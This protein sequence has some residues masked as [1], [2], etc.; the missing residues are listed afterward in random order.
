MSNVI[1]IQPVA[2]EKIKQKPKKITKNIVVG[3]DVLE[4]LSGA[5][6]V[7]PLVI[8]R[9][10]IQNS[11][12]A[13]D[14][15]IN[16]RSLKEKEGFIE[17]VLDRENRSIKLIDNGAGLENKEF[18]KRLAAFGASKKRGTS[19]RGFRGVGRLSGFG[20]CRELIFRSRSSGDKLVYQLSWD[21]QKFKQ[22]LNDKN[23]SGDLNDV[24][25][26]VTEI[27]MFPSDSY[28]EHFFEVE[29]KG[30]IRCKN[31]LLLNEA[32]VRSYLEQVTPLPFNPDFKYA[33]EIQDKLDSYGVGKNYTIYLQDIHQSSDNGKEIPMPIYRPFSDSFYISDSL[34]DEFKG[35]QFFDLEGLDG[36]IVAFG[37]I[38]DHGYHGAFSNQNK[39]KG[40]RTRVG[41]I[42]VGNNE[43]LS[44]IF[45]QTRFNSWSI[46]EFHIIS[47]RICPNGRRDNFEQNAHYLNLRSQLAPICKD[48]A[49]TCHSKSAIRNNIKRFECEL[50]KTK[51]G[52]KMLNQTYV[53]KQLKS[54]L[55][56]RVEEALQILD[57]ILES[58]ELG[59]SAKKSLAIKLG[60]IRN[61][62]NAQIN[63]NFKNKKDPLINISRNKRSAYR[64]VFGLIYECSNDKKSAQKLIDKITRKIELS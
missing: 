1:D 51:D 39:L 18:A 10:Y 37:W 22:I 2:V 35:I 9:E 47:K 43:I 64:D 19:A 44:D 28:P 49:K 62:Y 56:E 12:D 48:I 6:Y 42:Q 63:G 54:T 30:V 13:I 52:L 32:E 26:E 55:R 53:N 36:E 24:V 5:M 46:G 40:L 21:G 3:K 59:K 33:R 8:F 45:T 14:E 15:A 17:I 31:D 58:K 57:Y 34:V 50:G 38:L 41:N 27:S 60:R 11:A 16:A 23:Y 7:N 61:K 29:L 4:L 25:K 20:Y